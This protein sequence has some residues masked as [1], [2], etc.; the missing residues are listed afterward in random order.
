MKRSALFA[1]VLAA[2]AVTSA[3]EAQQM[4]SAPLPRFELGVYAGGAYTTDWLDL[5]RD[6]TAFGEFADDDRLDRGFGFGFTPAFGATATYYLT[7][8]FGVRA[9]GAYVP[10]DYPTRGED[11][12]AEFGIVGPTLGAVENFR[13]DDSDYPLNNW[14]ADLSLV[15]RPW[16][17]NREGLLAS[18]YL[19]AG[20][21]VLVTDVAG[22]GFRGDPLIDPLPNARNCVPAYDALGACLSYDPDYATVG[23][24]TAGVGFDFLPLGNRLGLFAELAVHGYDSPFHTRGDDDPLFGESLADDEFAF[25]T[26]LVGGVKIGLGN[27]APATMPILPPPPMVDGAPLPPPPARGEQAIQVCVIE[28]RIVGDIDAVYLP[29]TG[30]TV[31]VEDGVRRPFAEAY[32]ATPP[33]YAAGA[34]FF[35]NSDPIRF[36]DRRYVRLG[37]PRRVRPSQV[38][39]IGEYQ[40]VGIF[41]EAG[42]PTPPDVLYIPIRPGCEFQPYESEQAVRGVRG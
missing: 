16:I 11:D 6:A 38:T 42:V 33:E 4:M 2:A 37:L 8:R 31:V 1:T 19:F 12:E 36:M 10:S 15:F 22:Q 39:R 29:S 30:D 24:G 14:L 27:L 25:T 9:H 32:P 17:A 41:G 7:P 3:G 35:L 18:T 28:G 34:E 13:D 26:R 40:G 23:Q 20:G 21:G 5:N